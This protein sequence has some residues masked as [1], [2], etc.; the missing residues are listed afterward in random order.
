MVGG[1]ERD[2]G[3]VSAFDSYWACAEADLGSS[4]WNS[5]ACPGFFKSYTQPLLSQASHLAD[6]ALAHAAALGIDKSEL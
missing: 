4:L 2:A 1:P 6:G 5:V 3:H